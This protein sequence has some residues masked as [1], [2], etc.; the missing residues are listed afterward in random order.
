MLCSTGSL[1]VRVPGGFA[2]LSGS[3]RKLSAE[4]K[5]RQSRDRNREHA[6]NTRLRKKAY[7]QKLTDLVKDLTA[8]KE[9]HQRDRT[10]KVKHHPL[11]RAGL[12]R[13]TLV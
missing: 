10:L 11:G 13:S 7:V 8:E 9:Q 2:Q 4:E 6:R 5:A 3:K 1:C 12:V